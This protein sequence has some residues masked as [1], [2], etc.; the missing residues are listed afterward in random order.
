MNKP[1]KT[2]YPTSAQ[3]AAGQYQKALLLKNQKRYSE[4]IE[5]LQQAIRMNPNDLTY[6]IE[7]ANC[8]VHLNHPIRAVN[9]LTPLY[10]KYPNNLSILKPYC[11]AL[12]DSGQPEKARA[13]LT[14]AKE[15][16][17]TDMAL[18]VIWDKLNIPKNPLK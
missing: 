4:A 14:K 9:I 18:K 5:F 6:T 1:D 7:M 12:V 8:Y 16:L 10:L 11:A 13:V 17:S 15:L 2:Y 3:A